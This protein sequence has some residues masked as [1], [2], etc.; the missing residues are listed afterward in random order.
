MPEQQ[1]QEKWINKVCFTNYSSFA[2]Y[3]AQPTVDCS[4]CF[5][6]SNLNQFF[7][8][9]MIYQAMEETKTTS[10][11]RIMQLEVRETACDT[12]EERQ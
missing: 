2:S 10:L 12:I 8:Y 11:A 3:D 1:I 9:Y 5:L 6:F 4:C 7:Q